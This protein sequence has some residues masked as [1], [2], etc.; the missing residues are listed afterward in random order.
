MTPAE[1]KRRRKKLGGSE[2]AA[3]LRLSP[4]TT[5]ARLYDEK[6]GIVPPKE[7]SGAREVGIFFED[8]IAKLWV[9]RWAKKR[10]RHYRM[11]KHRPL[12]HPV[13][14]FMRASPDRIVHSW[15]EDK[16][17]GDID[18]M[19]EGLEVKCISKFS[20]AAGGWGRSGSKD[21]PEYYKVQ[22]A[23]NR[24]IFNL[25][26]WNLI[27]LVADGK[28][29][30]KHYVYEK[31]EVYEQKL[32]EAGIHFWHNHI[33]AKVRPEET[34]PHRL[35]SPDASDIILPPPPAWMA[36]DSTTEYATTLPK[37]S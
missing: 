32:I 2:I 11:T 24:I 31:D 17:V 9:H 6:L 37:E 30:I 34:P 16:H 25:P 15:I 3:V 33:L 27:A 8:A 13:Y 22:C 5:A 4:F 12:C 28:Y 14:K 10:G 36:Q 19:D 23:W 21:Y 7:T 29:T 26:R 35:T 20:E 18:N 1:L